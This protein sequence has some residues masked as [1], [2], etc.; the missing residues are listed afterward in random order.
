MRPRL[1]ILSW[2]QICINATGLYQTQYDV[3]LFHWRMLPL[4]LSQFNSLLDLMYCDGDHFRWCKDK[5]PHKVSYCFAIIS[6][7][8]TGGQISTFHTLS[9]FYP[10]RLTNI[11]SHINTPTAGSTTQDASQF[12]RMRRLAQW[13]PWHSELW[14]AGDRTSKLPVNCQLPLPP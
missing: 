11:L 7:L 10:K 8:F 2:P 5:H 1:L 12:V 13:R 3:L 9:S 6:Y 4:T 14:G